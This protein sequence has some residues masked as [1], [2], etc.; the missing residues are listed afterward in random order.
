MESEL[1]PLNIMAR[2]LRVPVSWLRNEAMQGRVPCLI[3]GK[4]IL[5]DPAVVE[6]TLLERARKTEFNVLVNNAARIQP[7]KEGRP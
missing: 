7:P 6:T 1:L 5:C 2:R 4:Q 3:A